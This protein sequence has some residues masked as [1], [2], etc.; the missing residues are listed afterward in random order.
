MIM[1]VTHIRRKDGEAFEE[2]VPGDVENWGWEATYIPKEQI[3]SI[4]IRQK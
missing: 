3:A 1:Y 2:L 4:D